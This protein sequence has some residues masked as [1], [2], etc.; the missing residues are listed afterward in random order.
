MSFSKPKLDLTPPWEFAPIGKNKPK[1][2]PKKPPKKKK[3]ARDPKWEAYKK[4]V[5]LLTELN[6]NL[7]EGVEKRSYSGFHIDHKISKRFGYDNSIPA[8]HIAH[9]CNLHMMWWED[10]FLKGTYNIVDDL[11][12]WI[13][14]NLTV[15]P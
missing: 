3:G 4:Q 7:V 2:K 1:S 10:N 8:E 15:E 6:K 9:P 5:E 13:L 14:N 11:N 12:G